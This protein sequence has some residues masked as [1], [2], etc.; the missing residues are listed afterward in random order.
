MKILKF[1][2][3]RRIHQRAKMCGFPLEIQQFWNID[4]IMDSI[5]AAKIEHNLGNMKDS[6]CQ[7]STRKKGTPKGLWNLSILKKNRWW[8]P[9][10]KKG[11]FQKAYETCRFWMSLMITRLRKRWR[12]TRWWVWL[13]PQQDFEAPAM[14]DQNEPVSNFEPGCSHSKI[15]RSKRWRKNRDFERHCSLAERYRLRRWR[16]KPADPNGLIG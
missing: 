6:E 8:P 4:E 14:R 10:T 16:E 1:G 11:Q 3:K 15:L 5:N 7:P 2:R 9:N 13:Q 12:T